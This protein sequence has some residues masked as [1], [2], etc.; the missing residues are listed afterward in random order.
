[1]NFLTS[2]SGSRPPSPFKAPPG[3]AGMCVD[4]F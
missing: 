1:L 2:T 4:A 3:S